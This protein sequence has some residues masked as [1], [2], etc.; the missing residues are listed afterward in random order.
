MEQKKIP[1]NLV[2]WYLKIGKWE[3]YSYLVL[4]FLAMPLKYLF[5]MPWA[6][7]VVGLV[8]GLLFVAFVGLLGV[9]KFQRGMTFQNAVVSFLLSLVP[10]GSFYLRR[11]V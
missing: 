8:H 9:M 5:E 7:R 1:G 11:F 10:F 6:V 2:G 4:L 3:G